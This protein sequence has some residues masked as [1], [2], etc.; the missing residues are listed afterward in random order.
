[1]QQAVKK[2]QQFEIQKP[3]LKNPKIAVRKPPCVRACVAYLVG[4]PGSA[5]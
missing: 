5:L 2:R 4:G 3:A 1:M